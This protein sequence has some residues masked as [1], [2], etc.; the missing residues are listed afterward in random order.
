MTRFELFHLKNEMLVANFFANLFSVSLVQ[1]MM[2]RA[3]E[4][5]MEKI[6]AHSVIPVFDNGFKVFAFAFV[7]AMTLIYERPIRRYL[8]HLFNRAPISQDTETLARQRLLNEPFVLIAL[9]FSMWLLAAVLYPLLFTVVDAGS[10]VIRRSV[11]HSLSIGLM[12]ITIAFFLLEHV[13]QRRIT[14][15]LFPIGGLSEV[16][17]TLRIR[18]HTRLVAL[19]MA[20]NLIPLSSILYAFDNI[21]RLPAPPDMLLKNLHAVVNTNA[22]IFIGVGIFLTMLVNRN[23]SR[24]FDEILETLRKIR[25]GY[26]D[27][28]V[29]VT[30]NDEIGYTG[31][32]INEMAEGLKEREVMRQS[33][34][35]AKEVQQNL[36]PKS[37]PLYGNL[38]IA[39]RSIY[40]D[41]T[42][43]DYFDFI[44]LN[45]DLKEAIGLVVGDVSG[46]GIPSALLMATARAFL[47]LRSS[48]PGNINQIVNDV[49][50]QLTRDVEASGQFMTLFY[51]VI[52]PEEKSLRWV[53]AGHDPG[54]LYD[55]A[56][57]RFEALDGPGIALGL[58]ETWQYQEGRKAGLPE[59]QVIVIGTDG[60][61][62]AHNREGKMFGKAAFYELIRQQA[63]LC[64]NDILD[65]ILDAL[66]DFQK[67]AEIEDDITLVVIKT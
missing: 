44:H 23:L 6:W 38:D 55:P 30:S 13:S 7:A 8:T 49:N 50:V 14:P 33:L 40:C 3:D 64:A 26:F 10:Y 41:Q 17:G 66:T 67:S 18:T 20:S 35:L 36:L 46:H 60:V 12:T 2:F 62:E 4:P 39:G 56:K 29:R 27:G 54:I 57:D 15:Y 21:T 61:W 53:R 43:G 34:E 22:L 48:L 45:G 59:G 19:L 1:L 16:P 65:G 11:F 58:D 9:D 24:P 51:L 25:N 32:V 42:G 5:L 47:R 37:A 52:D 28:K 63:G 31:D